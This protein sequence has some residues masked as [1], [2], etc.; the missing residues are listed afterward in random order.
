MEVLPRSAC[1]DIYVKDMFKQ[2]GVFTCR[3]S[4]D[5]RI[6]LARQSVLKRTVM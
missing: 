3:E 4:D 5:N 6:Y 1:K 2:L